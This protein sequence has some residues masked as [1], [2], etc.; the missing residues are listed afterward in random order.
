[1]SPSVS[2]QVRID[3]SGSRPRLTWVDEIDGHPRV[4]RH[5]PGSLWRRFNAWIAGAIGLERML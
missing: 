4:L 5:E 1:M 3:R 2:Y